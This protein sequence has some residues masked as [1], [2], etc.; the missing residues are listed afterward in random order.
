MP[1][2]TWS[3]KSAEDISRGNNSF[4]LSHGATRTFKSFPYKLRTVRIVCVIWS[5]ESF[6]SRNNIQGA[7]SR[8]INISN[9]SRRY[10]I[11]DFRFFKM[12]QR[13]LEI[14]SFVSN[15]PP[16]SIKSF[17]FPWMRSYSSII[18]LI[19]FFRSEPVKTALIANNWRNDLTKKVGSHYSQY[20]YAVNFCEILLYFCLGHFRG[21]IE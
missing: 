4:S 6:I 8:R 13:L 3:M 18:K 11:L 15:N 5:L 16:L 9:S 17:P 21:N 10:Y 1:W 2:E 20:F 12:H 7:D 19:Q 14:S